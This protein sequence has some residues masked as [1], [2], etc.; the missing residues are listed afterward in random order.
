MIGETRVL[1]PVSARSSMRK[2]ARSRADALWLVGDQADSGFRL[3]VF[4]QPEFYEYEL[5]TGGAFRASVAL[6][7][8]RALKAPAFRR[9][10]SRRHLRCRGYASLRSSTK[11]MARRTRSGV[12][13][14]RRSA[15]KRELSS[16][17]ALDPSPDWPL[18]PPVPLPRRGPVPINRV[19]HRS[20]EGGES[21]SVEAR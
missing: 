15:P 21:I 17:S 3:E 5:V 2:A 16:H 4:A 13:P 19:P 12:V 8:P 1:V 10:S 9:A 11:K 7:D 6:L 20:V 14:T 18:R